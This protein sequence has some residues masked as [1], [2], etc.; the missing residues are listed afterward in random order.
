MKNTIELDVENIK[1]SGCM[2]TI[3]GAML[4]ME[5][6]QEV[7]IDLESEHIHLEGNEAMDRESIVKKLASLGYP[8]V[9]NNNIIRKAVS[10]VSCAVG[11]LEKEN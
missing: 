6:V 3:K 8:E 4:K 9:G 2:N 7:S 10:F 11:R 1:C 5:G